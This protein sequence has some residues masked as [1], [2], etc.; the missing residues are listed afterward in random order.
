MFAAAAAASSQLLGISGG[1][2][3]HFASKRLWQQH[4]A[5]KKILIG[6]LDGD[7]ITFHS[8][9]S[10]LQ[11]LSMGLFTR[12]MREINPNDVGSVPS[13]AR[14]SKMQERRREIISDT[15]V[16]FQAR[17]CPAVVFAQFNSFSLII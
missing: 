7:P 15:S 10:L 9:A 14:A 12:W 1:K 8:S 17:L 2:H 4:L 5:V 16:V 6:P 3:A 11:T 13:G